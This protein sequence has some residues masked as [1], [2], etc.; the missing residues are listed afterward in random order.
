MLLPTRSQQE[1]LPHQSVAEDAPKF[2]PTWNASGVLRYELA[3]RHTLGEVGIH[4]IWVCGEVLNPER[5]HQR[6]IYRDNAGRTLTFLTYGASYVDVGATWRGHITARLPVVCSNRWKHFWFKLNELLQH[7]E[8]VF[9]SVVSHYLV[10]N[11]YYIHSFISMVCVNE[12]LIRT[13]QKWPLLSQK[14]D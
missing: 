9:T 2:S 10:S 6:K 7:M 4:H 5:Q 3:R 11:T 13:L 14:H 12:D 1:D 8:S